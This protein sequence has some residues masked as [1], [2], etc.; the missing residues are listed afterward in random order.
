[1]RVLSQSACFNFSDN[2]E[3]I[4]L[5]KLGEDC[6]DD[7]SLVEGDVNG[8]EELNV[9]DVVLTVNFILGKPTECDLSQS[10]LDINS[11]GT[12]NILDVV[13]MVGQILDTSQ[14]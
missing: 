14:G 13:A 8:D 4:L 1:V 6:P 2:W 9:L 10:K 12:V 5:D 7:T 11:D 3:D